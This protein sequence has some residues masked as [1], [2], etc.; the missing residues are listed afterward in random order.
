MARSK[1][2]QSVPTVEK[3]RSRS[4]HTTPKNETQTNRLQR[5]LSNAANNAASFIRGMNVDVKLNR[6]G[7]PEPVMSIESIDNRPKKER[8]KERFVKVRRF[9]MIP[10]D[11]AQPIISNDKP[12]IK[13]ATPAEMRLYEALKQQEKDWDHHHRKEEFYD[14]VNKFLGEKEKYY[15]YEDEEKNDRFDR[16][17]GEK[18]QD[19]LKML[20]K[21]GDVDLSNMDD[22]LKDWD[23]RYNEYLKSL[24][25]LPQL[26]R[27]RFRP[28]VY[29]Q[30]EY[31]GMVT[32]I[33]IPDTDVAINAKILDDEE[34][35]VLL[36]LS[37]RHGRRTKAYQTAQVTQSRKQMAIDRYNFDLQPVIVED[38]SKLEQEMAM[39]TYKRRKELQ[40]LQDK[41]EARERVLAKQKEKW[42]NKTPREMKRSVNLLQDEQEADLDNPPLSARQRRQE[43][44]NE[45][46]DEFKKE[47]IE[48]MRERGYIHC[49]EVVI[50]GVE[51]YMF[52][53]FDSYS[54]ACIIDAYVENG[55]MEPYL[56]HQDHKLLFNKI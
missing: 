26:G 1:S 2:P 11:V 9:G 20:G 36:E 41:K 5:G 50:V 56:F 32:R 48:I 31:Y 4:F 47:D 29:E 14:E 30:T 15:L 49:D 28:G 45:N 54:P 33:A 27:G 42:G 25:K 39:E 23:L 7:T 19:S 6:F 12:N 8:K 10:Q 55:K 21:Q 34:F 22:H 52:Y 17:T 44:K 51:R 53:H 46:V 37:K 18:V 38:Q 13:P 16:I 24:D 3:S 35:K 43:R 40:L